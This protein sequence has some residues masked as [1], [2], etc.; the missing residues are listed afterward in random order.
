MLA[1]YYLLTS[2]ISKILSG[3]RL[4]PPSFRTQVTVPLWETEI[5]RLATEQAF[6]CK[7]AST[8]CLW[9]I[10]YAH[11]HANTVKKVPNSSPGEPP[12]L[13]TVEVSLLHRITLWAL[14]YAVIHCNHLTHTEKC[15]GT[16]IQRIIPNWERRQHPPIPSPLMYKPD[17]TKTCC[18]EK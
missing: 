7:V 9:P 4:P 14:F 6:S 2:V 17:V 18:R 15:N 8:T 13:P 5:N 3:S 1:D 11:T 16:L 12:A 10:C